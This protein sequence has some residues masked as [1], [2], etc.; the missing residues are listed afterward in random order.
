[1]VPLGAPRG[2]LASV[3]TAWVPLEEQQVGEEQALQQQV[4]R[5]QGLSRAWEA[6]Q[7]TI[8]S[9]HRRVLPLLPAWQAAAVAEQLDLVESLLKVHLAVQVGQ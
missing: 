9:H 6:G 7:E 4:T 2:H 8:R 1:M 5:H 3:A